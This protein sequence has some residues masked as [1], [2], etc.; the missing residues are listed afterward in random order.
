MKAGRCLHPGIRDDNPYRTK[1]GS[2]GHHTGRKKM[3]TPAETFDQPNNK[4][5]QKT[6]LQKKG[7]HSLGCQGRTKHIPYVA[8][9]RWPNWFQTQI[10]LRCRSR[11]QWRK[12]RA[13]TTGP[14]FRHLLPSRIAR[15]KIDPFHNDYKSAPHPIDKGG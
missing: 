5:S 15:F 9:S 11:R 7:E 2:E 1:M 8:E 4:I 13:N 14:K 10:P 12:V 3:Q 6:R